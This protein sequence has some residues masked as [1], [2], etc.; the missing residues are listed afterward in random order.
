MDL[1]RHTRTLFVSATLAFGVLIAGVALSACGDDD[2]TTTNGAAA[3]DKAGNGID[4]A[5]VADMIPHHESAVD[6]A[7]IAK[8]RGQSAF[9]KSLADDIIRSQNAE[10]TAMQ[11]IA[12]RLDEAGVKPE[13][14]GV[15][16]HQMGM[17]NDLAALRKADPFDREFIDMMIPHHQG[18]IRMARVQLAKGSD[19]DTKQLATAI[20]EAQ[21]REINAMNKHRTAEFG[22]PSPAGDVPPE[23]QMTDEPQGDEMSGMDHG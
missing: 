17:D 22:A 1:T 6:M 3:T 7:K 15:A 16:E 5:F 20:I 19:A 23:D 18:A 4:R 21:A 14:L 10:I 12:A 2:S 9:V 8:S 13:S 11:S